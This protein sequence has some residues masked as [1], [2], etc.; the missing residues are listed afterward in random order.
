MVFTLTLKLVLEQLNVMYCSVL[1]YKLHLKIVGQVE[2]VE[3]EQ[4]KI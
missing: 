4:L 2:K 1:Y 3:E